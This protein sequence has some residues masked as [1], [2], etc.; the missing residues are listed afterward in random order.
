MGQVGGVAPEESEGSERPGCGRMQGSRACKAEEEAE[1][2][3][4]GESRLGSGST[5]L[6]GGQVRAGWTPEGPLPAWKYIEI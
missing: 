6:L 4:K 5:G 2:Q 1:L 3:Q